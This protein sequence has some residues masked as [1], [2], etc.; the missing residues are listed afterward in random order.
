MTDFNTFHRFS[1]KKTPNVELSYVLKLCAGRI[2]H[3]AFVSGL[4]DYAYHYYSKNKTK[5]NKKSK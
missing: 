5:T 3:V 4:C 1:T 2:M